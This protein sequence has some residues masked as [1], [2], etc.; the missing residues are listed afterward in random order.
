M[1]LSSGAVSVTDYMLHIVI[2]TES[3]LALSEL[4]ILVIVV[5]S[6]YIHLLL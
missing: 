1:Y 2:T 6:C 4:L 5:L 3:N